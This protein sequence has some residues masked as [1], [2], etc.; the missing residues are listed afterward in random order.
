MQ[1]LLFQSNHLAKI[2]EGG[3]SFNLEAFQLKH[4]FV[5]HHVFHCT[6]TLRLGHA[7]ASEL[8]FE[9]PS[10]SKSKKRLKS[11]KKVKSWSPDNYST[12]AHSQLLHALPTPFHSDWIVFIAFSNPMVLKSWPLE[13][14]SIKK[15]G[16]AGHPTPCFLGDGAR[17]GPSSFSSSV[18][19][20]LAQRRRV[21]EEAQI[22][23]YPK[24]I[25][26]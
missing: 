5:S 4:G 22:G 18:P 7:W 25:N 24:L 23:R 1:F 12:L 21:V 17:A 16:G 8:K 2:R 10:R 13:H 15:H 6:S 26:K 19:L 3:R 20:L 11:L 14:V 9:S